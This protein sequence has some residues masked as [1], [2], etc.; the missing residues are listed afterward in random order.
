MNFT[1]SNQK[2]LR[3][4]DC[5]MKIISFLDWEVLRYKIVKLSKNVRKY[6]IAHAKNLEQERILE[7]DFGYGSHGWTP[8]AHKIASVIQI[9]IT[10]IREENATILQKILDM[11]NQL[12]TKINL[13]AAYEFDTFNRLQ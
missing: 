2:G 4:N 7:V 5:F 9:K 1:N 13:Y 8:I 3:S 6:I 10:S 11:P 12:H